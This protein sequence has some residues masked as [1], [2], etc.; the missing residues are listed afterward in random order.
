[1]TLPPRLCRAAEPRRG[2]GARVPVAIAPATQERLQGLEHAAFGG[3]A[4]GADLYNAGTALLQL[5]DHAQAA[6]ALRAA[7][8]REPDFAHARLNLGIALHQLGRAAEA[9]DELRRAVALAPDDANALGALAAALE[10]DRRFGAAIA[11]R[12]RLARLH[13]D[14]AAAMVGLGHLLERTGR[15]RAAVAVLRLALDLEPDNV[16]ALTTLGVTLYGLGRLS[17]SRAALD[18]VLDQTPGD[19]AARAARAFMRLKAGDLEAGWREWEARLKTPDAQR[20]IRGLA[21]PR[22]DGAP[23]PGGVVLLVAEQGLGDTMQMARYVA[24]V[25]ER[26]GKAVLWVPPP[27]VRLLGAGRLPGETAP[28]DQRPPPHDAW[29]PMFSLPALFGPASP[30]DPP[31]PY[32]R[33]DLDLVRHWSARLP[34]NRPRIGVVWRGSARSRVNVDRSLPAAALRPLAE[35][36]GARLISLQKDATAAELAL[37]HLYDLG[38]AFRAG[39]FADTAAI[40]QGLDLIVSCDTAAA[41]LAGGLGRPVW[42]ALGA[43]PDWRW[44]QNRDDTIWYRSMR[45]F[46]RANGESWP[47]LVTRMAQ[48]LASGGLPQRS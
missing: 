29:I 40:M 24:Q 20:W 18:R 37:D 25:R 6:R 3:M 1:M 11:P 16:R 2:P 43:N 48:D 34:E 14:S 10:A 38:E 30:D 22:W 21:A 23:L 5:G 47:A 4:G 13:P 26:V 32:L 17:E 46:R 31:P 12:L 41:H 44:L 15:Y 8:R 39:D 7:I 35:A 9:V 42:V 28:Q 33:A 36:C 19:A 27:L 45:L